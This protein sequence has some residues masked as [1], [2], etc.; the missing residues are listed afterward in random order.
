MNRDDIKRWEYRMRVKYNP[1]QRKILFEKVSMIAL[2]LVFIGLMVP[3]WGVFIWYLC[4]SG[5]SGWQKV[6]MVAGSY[7]IL[8][9]VCKVVS[10]PGFGAIP[11]KWDGR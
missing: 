6:E 10:I 7:V 3:S 1:T 2:N 9:L 4:G 11:V 8:I 5:F